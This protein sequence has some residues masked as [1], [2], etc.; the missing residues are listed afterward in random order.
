MTM[1]NGAHE[2]RQGFPRLLKDFRDDDW[3]QDRLDP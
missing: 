2:R 1:L 3:K